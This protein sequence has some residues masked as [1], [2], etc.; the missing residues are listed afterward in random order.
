MSLFCSQFFS[1]FL[2]SYWEANSYY[3]W[4]LILRKRNSPNFKME[5]FQGIWVPR[6]F[7]LYN[8][9]WTTFAL[10]N[11]PNH[12]KNQLMIIN[13]FFK[14]CIGTCIMGKFGNMNR[15]TVLES[16]NCLSTISL[17]L[18]EVAFQMSK[19]FTSLKLRKRKQKQDVNNV[20]KS[21]LSKE[22]KFPEC[23]NLA[24]A[25]MVSKVSPTRLTFWIFRHFACQDLCQQ[26]F[27]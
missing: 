27:S 1:I 11:V 4:G 18:C 15:F 26:G 23:M 20:I 12:S 22:P 25:L 17:R 14:K 6:V 24:V 13:R 21:L 9:N 7:S 5:W 8:T 3:P 16:Q 19:F 2:L 10:P